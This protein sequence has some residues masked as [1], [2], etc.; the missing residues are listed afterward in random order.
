MIRGTFGNYLAG[1]DTA[2]EK[3]VIR[4]NW[5]DEFVQAPN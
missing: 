1:A 3:M 4:F 2:T 5:Q